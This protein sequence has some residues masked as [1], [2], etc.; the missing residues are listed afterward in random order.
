MSGGITQG[1]KVDWLST[2]ASAREYQFQNLRL[3][4]SR[5]RVNR[6]DIFNRR[7]GTSHP[8]ELILLISSVVSCRSLIRQHR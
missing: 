4:D 2:S 5:Y 6:F 8:L 1:A 7:K 3:I